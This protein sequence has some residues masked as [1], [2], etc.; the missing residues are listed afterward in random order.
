M[1]E[2]SVDCEDVSMVGMLVGCLNCGGVVGSFEMW[3][4]W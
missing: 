2:W 4:D 3:A 1:S